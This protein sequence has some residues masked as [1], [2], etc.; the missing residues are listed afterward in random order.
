M[1]PLFKPYLNPDGIL[2]IAHAFA[3]NY[4]G[5]G[6]QVKAFEQAL[7]PWIGDAVAVNSGTSALWLA[8]DIA[9]V[10]RGALVIA[11]PMSCLASFI[12]LAH[13]GAEIIWC[14]V[15]PRTGLIDVDDVRSLFLQYGPQIA[16][17]VAVDYGGQLVDS[18]SLMSLCFKNGARF[19]IDCAHSFGANTVWDRADFMCYSFQAIK[20]LTTGDGGALVCLNPHE[21]KLAQLKRWFGLDRS[22][23][24][25]RCEQTVIDA[26]YKFHMNDIAAGIGLA[27][28][29]HVQENISRARA[30]AFAYEVLGPHQPGVGSKRDVNSAWL[31]TIHVPDRE[32]FISRMADRGVQCARVHARCDTQPIFSPTFGGVRPLPGVTEFDR[33]QV[34]IP[35]GYWLS[36]D[37]VQY[38]IKSVQESLS[39]S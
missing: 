37:D 25:F 4:V 5:E 27:N 31:H 28:L 1:I 17:V 30:H 20:H 3:D 32:Q 2:N 12:P 26:G 22:K 11:T 14:D 38:V 18:R 8:Y 23:G 33:T 13:I 7:R 15:D 29:P 39:T 21:T 19:I 36:N 24:G 16:A 34:S 10:K 6:P 9:G 35:V